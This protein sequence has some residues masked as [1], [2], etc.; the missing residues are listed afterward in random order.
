MNQKK[1]IIFMPTID[2]GGVEKN[3][4]LIT[5]YLSTKFKDISVISLSKSYQKEL[6]PKIKFITFETKLPNS[7]GRRTKFIISLFLLFKKI[8]S[9]RNSIVFCFQGLAYCTI[10][11]KLLST[12]I[13]IRSN[14]SPSGWSNKHIKKNLYK[15]IYSMANKI[16]VNSEEFKKE[17]KLKFNLN[18]ECIYNPLNKKEIIK[19]SKKKINISFFKKKNFK[20]ISVARFTSQKDHFCLIRSI[21]LLKIKYKNIKVL[22]IGSG[23]KKKEIQNLINELRLNKLIK[24]LNFKKNPYPYI[25]KSNLFILS[26]NFEGLPNVLLEAITL[27]KFIISS[28]CPTGPSEIL[29][30][31]KGGLLFKVGDYKE[32]SKKIIYTIHNKK[33]CNEKL[34]FAKKRL[35]R[36]DFSKNLLKYYNILNTI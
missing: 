6:N 27:N 3:F 32:L 35:E 15:K 2:G 5:N 31:G 24:I 16:I 9:S 14:S 4:F 25:K 21:N 10:L 23:N 11:C 36:F 1:I 29:D 18:S 28:N 33:K 7:I 30:N 13:I 12:K 8:L 26:S 22:L 20:I 34:L 19:N 17:L